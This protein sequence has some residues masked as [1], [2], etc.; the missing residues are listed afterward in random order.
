MCGGCLSCLLYLIL[1]VNKDRH[2]FTETLRHLKKK[3]RE[4]LQHTHTHSH[5]LYTY[6]N[7]HTLTYTFRE[8]LAEKTDKFLLSD[9][10]LTG[11]LAKEAR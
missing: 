7:T 5:I 1:R 4:V 11:P 9:T 3:K 10:K 6:T 8:S 2:L